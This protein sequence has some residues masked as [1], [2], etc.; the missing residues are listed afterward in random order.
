MEFDWFSYVTVGSAYITVQNILIL[1]RRGEHD[2]WYVLSLGISP[3]LSQHL[4]AYYFRKLKVQEYQSGSG[5]GIT[6]SMSAFS[7]KIVEGFLSIA[8]HIDAA[9]DVVISER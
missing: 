9:V 2:H 5:A 1:T 7:E 6:I 3:D 8:H 4:E